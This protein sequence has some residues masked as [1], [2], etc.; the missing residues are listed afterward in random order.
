MVTYSSKFVQIWIELDSKHVWSPK[1]EPPNIITKMRE[2]TNER[3]IMSRYELR[4]SHL[5]V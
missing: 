4:D 5:Q 2:T 3:N 1:L